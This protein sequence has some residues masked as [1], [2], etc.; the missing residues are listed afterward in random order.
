V[1]FAAAQLSLV[2]SSR[3]VLAPVT[4]LIFAVVGIY[5]YRPNPIQG[6]FAVT[7]VLTAFFC[8]WLVASV[9]REVTPAAGAILTVLAGGAVAAWRGRLALVGFFTVVLTVFCLI[10]P[11]ATGAFDRTP[12]V[13][14]LLAGALA[15][16]ACAA[17]GGTLALLLGPPLRT[18]TAFTVIL[19]VLIASI[20]VAAPLEVVAGPGGVAR[21]LSNTPN[22]QV[23]ASLV[24]ACAIAF[25]AAGALGYA[26][27][28]QS[29][30]RG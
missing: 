2:L 20:A 13:G 17:V 8:A 14:D 1:S 24:V 28:V 6:S 21:A 25:V 3:R 4:L 19:A 18:A 30:W 22:D 5:F 23:S 27:R 26:A 7:A 29:R 15:H 10:W 12:G 16:L 9:E 11:T